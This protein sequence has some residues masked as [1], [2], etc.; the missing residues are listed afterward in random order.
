MIII[1]FHDTRS[2]CRIKP[3]EGRGQKLQLDQILNLEMFQKIIKYKYLY[4]HVMF[5]NDTRNVNWQKDSP[6]H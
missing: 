3:V 5:D 2:C 1:Q 4:L 6:K